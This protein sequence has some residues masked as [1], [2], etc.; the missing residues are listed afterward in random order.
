MKGKKMSENKVYTVSQE[1]YE[2]IYAK[3]RQLRAEAF[4]SIFSTI[5]S[6]VVSIPSKIL[7]ILSRILPLATAGKTDKA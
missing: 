4:V 1:E 2:A 7:S 6:F 3:A 5:F